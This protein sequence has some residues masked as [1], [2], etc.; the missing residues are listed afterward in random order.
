MEGDSLR[1]AVGDLP[2]I[3][4]LLL[5]AFLMRRTLLLDTGY[6]G[7]KIIGSRFSPSA[8]ELRDFA[9]RNAIPFIW[10]DLERDQGAEEILRHFGIPGRSSSSS[11][12]CRTPT[13]WEM[14]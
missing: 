2:E 1:S 6:E 13:G 8:H 12:P 3:G 9:A 4:E 7:F 5:K 14:P 11:G 10:L